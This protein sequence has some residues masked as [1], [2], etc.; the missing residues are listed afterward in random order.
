MQCFHTEDRKKWVRISDRLIEVSLDGGKTFQPVTA[1]GHPQ[2]DGSVIYLV[3][4]R[5][6]RFHVL[7]NGDGKE[8]TPRGERLVPA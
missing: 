1:A 7:A 6:Y 3:A 5:T 8:P 2:P 4:G